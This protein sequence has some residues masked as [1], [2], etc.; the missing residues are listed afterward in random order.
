MEGFTCF[1]D[2]ANSRVFCVYGQNISA[3]PAASLGHRFWLCLK[4]YSFW[5]S[6]F[7]CLTDTLG[8]MGEPDLVVSVFRALGQDR[9]QN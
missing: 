6:I 8:H 2:S 5:D 7:K 9:L 1:V 3:I 4:L